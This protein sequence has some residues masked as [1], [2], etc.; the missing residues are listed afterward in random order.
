MGTVRRLPPGISQ[1]PNGHYLIRFRNPEG[2]S[3]KKTVRT[4]EQAKAFKTKTDAAKL[5]GTYVDLAAR[6]VTVAK[7]AEKWIETKG[8][9]RARTRINVEGRLRNHILP[10]FGKRQLGT[11]RRSDVQAWVTAMPRAPATVKATYLTTSPS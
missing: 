11:I 6:K 9:V 8:K 1:L 10:A 7:W 3:R 4:L 5:D 2:Q